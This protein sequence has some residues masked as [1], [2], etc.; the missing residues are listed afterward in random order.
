MKC[1]AIADAVGQKRP[2][3]VADPF[4]GITDE[5]ASAD[6][7]HRAREVPTQFCEDTERAEQAFETICGLG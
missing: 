5:D 1:R 6:F 3:T 2:P 4:A 7:N